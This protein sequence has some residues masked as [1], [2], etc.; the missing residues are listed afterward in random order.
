MKITVTQQ[1]INEGQRGSSARDPV[2]FAMI[3][4]GCLRPHAGVTHLS[5]Q[6]AGHK[7]YSA[8]VPRVVYEFMLEFDN[9]KLVEPFEFTLEESK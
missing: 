5:W 3:D 1:H 4:A 6:D 9:G 7:R 8:E 2:A